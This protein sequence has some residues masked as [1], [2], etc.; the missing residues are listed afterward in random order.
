MKLPLH[1][2]VMLVKHDVFC[3]ELNFHREELESVMATPII[4]RFDKEYS[5]ALEI[6]IQ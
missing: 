2:V 1:C 4:L 3:E 5:Q 6:N